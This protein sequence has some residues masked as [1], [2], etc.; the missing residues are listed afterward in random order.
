MYHLSAESYKWLSGWLSCGANVGT[1]STH[2]IGEL[3]SLFPITQY[4]TD[5]DTIVLY[6]LIAESNEVYVVN[7][8]MTFDSRGK[9]TSWTTNR[10][11]A[12]IFKGGSDLPII[13]ASVHKDFVFIDTREIQPCYITC[14]IQPC[15]ITCECSGFPEE[16]EV[17]LNP[18]VLAEI[19]IVG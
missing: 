14:E 8:H 2:V 19:E 9:Y 12:D 3:S 5:D 1:P 7:E 16:K 13:R 18:C 10:K 4:N 11:V 6:R 17:I 15:Y